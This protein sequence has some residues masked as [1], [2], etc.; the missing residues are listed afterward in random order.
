MEITGLKRCHADGRKEGRNEERPWEK[1]EG[2]E[3]QEDR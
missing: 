1:G 2:E 3:L